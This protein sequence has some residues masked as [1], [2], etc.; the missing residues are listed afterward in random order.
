MAGRYKFYFT[1]VG[2]IIPDDVRGKSS[3]VV[4]N[5]EQNPDIKN[6]ITSNS[7]EINDNHLFYTKTSGKYIAIVYQFGDIQ[8][9]KYKQLHSLKYQVCIKSTKEKLTF[10]VGNKSYSVVPNSIYP[11]NLVCNDFDTEDFFDYKFNFCEFEEAAHIAVYEKIGEILY[12]KIG[13]MTLEIGRAAGAS[14]HACKIGKL[15]DKLYICTDKATFADTQL[16]QLPQYNDLKSFKNSTGVLCFD[17]DAACFMIWRPTSQAHMYALNDERELKCI[18]KFAL[19]SI[20]NFN[21]PRAPDL[22]KYEILKVYSDNRLKPANNALAPSTAEGFRRLVYNANSFG[23]VESLGGGSACTGAGFDFMIKIHRNIIRNLYAKYLYIDV[24]DVGIGKCRDVHAYQRYI[25]RNNIHGVEPNKDFSKFCTIKNVYTNTADGIFKYFDEHRLT[26]QF[27][28]IIFCNSYNFVTDPFITMKECEKYLSD[29]GRIIMVYM[30][31][32]KVITTKNAY[33]EI[34]KGEKNPE[35][36]SGHVLN[37][38][39]N[40]IQVFSETTLV[41]P[42]YENQISEGEITDAVEKVNAELPSDSEKLEIVEKGSLV[43]RLSTWLNPEARTFNS[44]FYYMVVGKPC[45]NNKI[46]IA[47]DLYTSTLKDY[48]D[49]MRGRSAYCNGVEIVR[50]AEFSDG[51]TDKMLCVVVKSLNELNKTIDRCKKINKKYDTIINIQ[52]SEELEY[53]M[54]YQ[55]DISA[56]IAERDKILSLNPQHS[57]FGFSQ[58]DPKM[59]S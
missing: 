34:R 54:I 53:A 26:N 7:H 43:H 50:F 15:S 37:G 30:N 17:L 46:T 9:V 47:V 33:Y 4:V 6:S 20:K 29:G 59:R 18:N 22:P 2:Y 35:L 51:P 10:S 38:R 58:S 11:R 8:V 42:H 19:A 16:H 49:Y 48:L 14:D 36:P 1:D 41:P 28:T 25:N 3:L 27:H 55:S 40:F 52:K 23:T 57:K 21:G 5:N 44:M 45:T 31:N 12:A 13:E 32:D 56:F 39:Q 24:L